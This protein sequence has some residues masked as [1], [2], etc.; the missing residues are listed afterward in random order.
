MPTIRMRNRLSKIEP[1]LTSNIAQEVYRKFACLT[2]KFRPGSTYKPRPKDYWRGYNPNDSTIYTGLVPALRDFLAKYGIGVTIV[3]ERTKPSGVPVKS[4]IELRPHQ[5]A[6]VERMTS[7]GRGTVSLC[8]G[9]GKTIMLL[10][11]FARLGVPGIMIVPTQTIYAQFYDS[12]VSLLDCKVGRIGQGLYDPGFLTIA[13]A[14]AMDSPQAR[15]YLKTIDFAYIDEGH[16]LAAKTWFSMLEQ[17]EIYYRFCGSGTAYRTDGQDIRLFANTGPIIARTTS[18]ELI[19]LGYL[20]K[21]NIKMIRVD[22]IGYGSPAEWA[23]YY[24]NN[25]LY[26]YERSCIARSIIAKCLIE[27]KKTLVLVAW[28]EHAEEILS[29]IPAEIIDKIGF[30]CSRLGKKTIRETLAAFAA[31]ELDVLFATTLLSEGYDLCSIDCLIRASGMQSPIKVTQETGR[32]LRIKNPPR[33]GVEVEVWDFFDDD[34]GVLT[35]HS[36]R[37]KKTWQR[38]P[39]FNVQV[40]D[41]SKQTEFVFTKEE[42]GEQISL[43][44]F[45]TEKLAQYNAEIRNRGL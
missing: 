27:K 13:I 20:A 35:R 32:V 30:V 39:A 3:D 22:G 5:V 14:A 23:L 1:A 11:A 10:E 9:S 40:I 18:S 43:S 24:K 37:R 41:A 25:V 45:R 7:V 4:H 44:D 12:A 19:E 38:E 34:G 36:N 28:E 8:T 31:G 16:H 21:P 15:K 2:K 42:E 33:L 26:N 29:G 6:P 17:S